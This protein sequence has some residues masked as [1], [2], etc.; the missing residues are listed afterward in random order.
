MVE[1]REILLDLPPFSNLSSFFSKPPWNLVLSSWGL[2][3]GG[4]GGGEWETKTLETDTLCEIT[5]EPL[6][7]FMN[8]FGKLLSLLKS[9]S[10]C[11]KEIVVYTSGI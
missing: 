6:T 11:K 2:R 8:N 10:V 5:F 4:G 1:A 7:S 3:S 9:L